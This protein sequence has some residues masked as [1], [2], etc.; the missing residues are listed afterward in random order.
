MHA[1]DFSL[2]DGTKLSGELLSADDR[3]VVF[4]LSDGQ[5]S[6]RVPWIKFTQDTLKQLGKN[7][8]AAKYIEP[9]LD[10]DI[11]KKAKKREVKI[12][13]WQKPSREAAGSFMGGFLG[14]GLGMLVLFL[15]YG[16][17]IYAA[18]EIAIV[19]AY[20]WPVVCG[21]AAVAPI[22]GPVFFLCMPTRVQSHGQE[23]EQEWKQYDGQGAVGAG[24]DAAA[25]EAAG[26]AAHAAAAEEAVAAGPQLPATERYPRG[27]FT[28]NR[29]FFETKFPSWFTVVRR[30][31]DKDLLII[32]K[33]ARGTFTTTR[34]SRIT[35]NDI[36]LHV[37][38][39][40]AARDVV[41]PYQE[42]QE[43][44]FKHKD[45]PDR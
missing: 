4:R 38:E 24:E 22:L 9:F 26:E 14:T 12:Q 17:S 7:S 31:A 15:V 45:A 10:V 19:R 3:G 11:S 37:A 44:I 28:F 43:V 34:F 36:T 33:T 41:V 23:T 18:Y 35:A 5:T 21:V 8:R 39:G 1:E 13:D 29:R 25:A 16:A 30:D 32:F 42:I 27:Q 20:P 2:T 40:Q 6:D